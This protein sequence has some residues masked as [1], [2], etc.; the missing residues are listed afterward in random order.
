MERAAATALVASTVAGLSLTVVYVTGGE[1]QLEG[2][3]LALCLG[4]IG[5]AM[6]LWGKEVGGAHGEEGAEPGVVTDVRPA[7]AS[8]AAPREDVAAILDRGT[9][10]L[11]R[12][13]RRRFLARFFAAAGAALGLAALFPLRSLGPSPGSALRR[14]AWRKG[15]RATVEGRPVRASDLDVGTVLTV[16]PDD[17]SSEDSATLL[18][19]VEDGQL[20]LPDDRAAWAPEGLVAYSKICTH[21]GCPVGLYRETTHEL[22]CP[23]HQSTFDVLRGARPTFG[24]AT[25]SLPQLPIEIDDQ[26]YVVARSDYQEPIGPG[27]WN[28]ESQP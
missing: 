4:G 1:P 10:A 18:I 13:D 16:F 14:T 28:R 21:V 15:S 24:P 23:C 6:G 2:I 7:M 17:S 20:Q 22:L 26:G 27:Y 8:D 9:A 11:D 5:V 3:L 25:R 19:R 12:L